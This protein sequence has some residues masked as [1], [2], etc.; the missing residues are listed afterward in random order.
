MK[1][2][3]SA[4][5]HASNLGE[6]IAEVAGCMREALIAR[7]L[8]GVLGIAAMLTI[9]PVMRLYG[10]SFMF[11][12]LRMSEQ[13]LL[14]GLESTTYARGRSSPFELLIVSF[15]G[16]VFPRTGIGGLERGFANSVIPM[17]AASRTAGCSRR[18]PSI[19]AGATWWPLTLMSS[20]KGVRLVSD[21]GLMLEEI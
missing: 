7:S 16:E 8:T 6:V 1:T 13:V 11:M 3:V 2:A 14:V 4:S 18:R 15:W 17:T 12:A 9:P 19:S 21:I 10:A 5:E 20:L